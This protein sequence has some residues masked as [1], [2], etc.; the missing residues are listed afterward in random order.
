MSAI[1]YEPR[2]GNLNE[3]YSV[4]Y[5][6]VLAKEYA[7]KAGIVNGP[8][9]RIITNGSTDYVTTAEILQQNLRD[10]GVNAVINNYD[11]AS[12]YGVN[13]DPAMFDIGLYATAS[14]QKLVV[15]MLYS[16]VLYSA[17][18][19]AGDW[20]GYDRFME[21]GR[22]VIGNPNAQERSDVVYEMTKIFVDAAPWYGLCDLQNA[23]AFNEK[24]GGIEF[25]SNGDFRFNEWYWTE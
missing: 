7:E 13:S 19:N 10:I 16:Y 17:I 4:G 11:L 15:G 1:D 20:A 22:G 18:L 9:I 25:Y 8:E 2:L 23:T 6:P 14:P 24:I 12:Y 5:D 3:T 21:L